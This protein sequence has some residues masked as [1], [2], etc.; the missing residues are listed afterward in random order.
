MDRPASLNCGWDQWI[1]IPAPGPI[2]AKRD[3]HCF[4]MH[5]QKLTSARYIHT[6]RMEAH[7]QNTNSVRTNRITIFRFGCFVGCIFR[8]YVLPE[9]PA[10]E[11]LK[12]LKSQ[13]VWILSATQWFQAFPHANSM[14]QLPRMHLN[15]SPTCFDI[16]SIKIMD[17]N[18][19][20]YF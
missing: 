19:I 4:Y 7:I 20:M 13:H 16:F 1:K 5:V 12:M 9:R 14:Q 17:N 2:F 18:K 15:T 10:K 3:F 11:L 8:K 6:K